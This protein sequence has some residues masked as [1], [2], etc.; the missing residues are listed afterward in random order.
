MENGKLKIK[1]TF[2]VNK[3]YTDENAGA[4]AGKFQ[5]MDIFQAIKIGDNEWITLDRAYQLGDALLDV[6]KGDV[7][8]IKVLRESV[9]TLVGIV[10]DKDEYFVQYA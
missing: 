8:T 5:Y 3:V 4:G 6:R 9:E 1:E 7:V 10:F 2:L